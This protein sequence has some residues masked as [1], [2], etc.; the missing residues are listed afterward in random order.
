MPPRRDSNPQSKQARKL[1]QASDRAAT[2]IGIILGKAEK[3]SYSTNEI[4][5]TYVVF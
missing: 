1:W 5:F 2:G 4:P 3:N